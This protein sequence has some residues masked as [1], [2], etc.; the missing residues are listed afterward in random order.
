MPHLL[1]EKR[2][3]RLRPWLLGRNARAAR[4]GRQTGRPAGASTP[5]APSEGP[6]H[7]SKVGTPLLGFHRLSSTASR[8]GEASIG[9]GAWG[10]ALAGTAMHACLL[11]LKCISGLPGR[12][13]PAPYPPSVRRM[14][15]LDASAIIKSRPLAVVSSISP[16][17]RQGEVWI[18]D[19]EA[20]QVESWRAG[21]GTVAGRRRRRAWPPQQGR[22]ALVVCKE[23]ACHVQPRRLHSKWEKAWHY[24]HRAAS[25]APLLCACVGRASGSKGACSAPVT[26]PACLGLLKLLAD[27]GGV[28]Q[29]VHGQLP[30]VPA[31]RRQEDSTTVPVLPRLLG[32]KVRAR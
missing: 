25:A 8:Q 5:P 6:H 17:R 12:A 4:K 30:T 19:G 15:Y 28:G 32:G 1:R 23:E 26:R 20:V 7:C 16:G 11:A 24:S 14:P 10:R 29:C 3:E 9:S 21:R 18:E 27:S 2:E 13:A 22:R 31:C